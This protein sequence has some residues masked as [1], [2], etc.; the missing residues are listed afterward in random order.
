M[1]KERKVPVTPAETYRYMAKN[2]LQV[3][4][5]NLTADEICQCLQENW[6]NAV[7]STDPNW[8]PKQRASLMI[9]IGVSM[10]AYGHL[11]YLEETLSAI[12]SRLSDDYIADCEAVMKRWN[13]VFGEYGIET[14]FKLPHRAF[15]RAVGEFS[16][17][18][19][20]PDG[21]LVTEAEWEERHA[22][23]LPSE[24][25]L[26]YILSLMEPEQRP[27]Q[28]ASWIAAPKAGI[29][30]KPGDF[31]YVKLAA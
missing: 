24:A 25:D 6:N 9:W 19:A 13:R 4:K 3:F 17:V 1:T 26:Q 22:E 21:Q 16:E 31:E 20:T 30:G 29:N 2:D 5:S 15:H 14:T 11:D 12:N 23:W 10:L 27:G 18:R 7:S 8:T 28:Y